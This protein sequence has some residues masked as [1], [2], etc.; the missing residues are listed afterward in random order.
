MKNGA[1]M[2]WLKWW[3]SDWLGD[4]NLRLCSRAAKGLWA[5][6]RCLMHQSTPYGHLIST[7][8][9]PLD[10]AALCSMLGGTPTEIGALLDELE[11]HN[12]FSR[13]SQGVIFCRRLVH[14]AHIHEVRADAGSR[15]GKKAAKK[16][17]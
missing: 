15:G 9:Q 12:V 16:K 6:M 17:G 2:P 8:G 3:V 11:K 5:D 1:P 7:A 10:A 4:M 13:T 14:D